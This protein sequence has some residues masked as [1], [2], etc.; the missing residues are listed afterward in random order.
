[1]GLFAPF[2]F[3]NARV[4]IVGLFPVERRPKVLD[5]L[6]TFGQG[7]SRS[8]QIILLFSA[9]QPELKARIQTVSHPQELAVLGQ[10][11][12]DALPFPEQRF[13][14]DAHGNLSLRIGIC[15]QQSFF[16]E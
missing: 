6:V 4:D 1:M 10:P 8:E 12:F 7:E 3:R 15:D 14:R 11:F 5:Q 9:A 13:V 2:S 16:N